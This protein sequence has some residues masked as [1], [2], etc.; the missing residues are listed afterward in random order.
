MLIFF[1]LSSLIG[2]NIEEQ[3]TSSTNEPDRVT[4]ES[5]STIEAID[6]LLVERLV[7][8]EYSTSSFLDIEE[9]DP[10]PTEEE[11]RSAIESVPSD[12][13]EKYPALQNIP[14]SATLYKDGEVTSIALDD[15]R[16]IRL[17]NFFNNALHYDK[18]SYLL[19][20]VTE[21]ILAEDVMSDD[22]RLELKFKPFGDVKP[23]PYDDNPS[24][25]DTMIIT[26]R[27]F[28]FTLINHDAPIMDGSGG[29]IIPFTAANYAPYFDCNITLADFG[30]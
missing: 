18:C 19:C 2:C 10:D 29:I 1:L 23:A 24:D 12:R 11:I 7:S 26:N 15:P 21:E 8:S 30:F 16:L 20:Y 25:F 5:S 13:Y 28:D 14:L 9:A 17:I 4:E 6:P 3:E 27:L 22:F